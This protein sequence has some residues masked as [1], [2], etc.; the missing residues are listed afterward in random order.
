[1]MPEP[2]AAGDRGERRDLGPALQAWRRVHRDADEV[3]DAVDG[4]EAVLVGRLRD[5]DRLRP[6]RAALWHHEAEAERVAHPLS[7]STRRARSAT[8]ATSGPSFGGSASR[9]GGKP[10]ASSASEQVGPMDAT[11]L[12]CVPRRSAS[13]SGAT[14][15][16]CST[17]TALVKSTTC[18]VPPARAAAAASSGPTSRGSAHR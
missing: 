16:R 11:T 18:A 6:G 1:E 12:R 10:C 8:S 13:A 17:C 5:L 15:K 9:S 3:V 4:V 2:Y 14:R 7:S